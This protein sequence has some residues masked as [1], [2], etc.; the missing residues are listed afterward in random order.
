MMPDPKRKADRQQRDRPFPWRCPRCLREDAVDLQTMPYTATIAHDGRE[1]TLEIPEIQI[2]Q[3][4]SCKELIL[5]HRVEERIR[6]ALRPALRAHLHL[7]TPEQIRRGREALNFSQAKLAERLGVASETI[8]RWETGN[9]IQSRAMDNLLRVY[10]AI[11]EVRA[12]LRGA[13]QDPELGTVT[14]NPP[15]EDPPTTLRTEIA[16]FFRTATVREKANQGKHPICYP[17]PVE[18]N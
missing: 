5:T 10:F 16:I 4:R 1:Y 11:P 17:F 3:C 12:V 6:D 18:A 7:L 13:E 8:S 2:P 9:L 14:P 15:P